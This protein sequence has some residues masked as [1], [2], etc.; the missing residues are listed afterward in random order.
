MPELGP[1][2]F[3]ELLERGRVRDCYLGRQLPPT[4]SRRTRGRHRPH[5]RPGRA[6][7]S[8]RSPARR[9]PAL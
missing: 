2:A 5:R 3:G 8:Q 9:K 1:N 6:A 4:P 7:A